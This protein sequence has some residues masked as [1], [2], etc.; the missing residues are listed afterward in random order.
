MITVEN[1]STLTP[2]RRKAI[3]SRSTVDLS[4][5]AEK[6]KVILER[7]RADPQKELFQEYGSYK[8][9]ICL[10]DFKASP[11]EIQSALETLTPELKSALQIA[12]DNIERFHQSQLEKPMYMTEISP[13][14]LT[15]RLTRPLSKVGVYIPGGL[16]S[17]PSS[18]LM[19]IIPAKV[20]GVETIVAATPPGL[21]LKARPEI[22]AACSLAGATEI[23]KLGG[24]WAIG[25]LAYGLAG[26]PKV[27]KIVG[28]GSSWV[29]AAKMAVFG[30]VDVD[31]PAGPSEGFIIADRTAQPLHLAWDFLSQLEHDPQASAVLVTTCQELATTVVSSVNTLS[32]RLERAEIV[33]ESLANAAILY[34]SSLTEAFDFANIYAPEH[35]Q[36]IVEEAISYLGLIKNAGSIFLGPWSPIPAGD[37]ATGPNHVLPTGGSARAFSGLST[38]SFLKKMTFQKLTHAALKEL[39]PTITTLALAEG[40]P[41]HAQT[42]L[43]RS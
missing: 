43:V 13:G 9:N 40:L 37:Y 26:V 22:L 24:A 20:A 33:R 34:C 1:L 15:G 7:L 38:D 18:A 4:K 41:A 27:D 30:E 39:S 17:Y 23:Y 8:N 5:V 12:A 21:D 11:Q 32:H 42:I 10:E 2:E 36:I 29:T 19:N 6:T 16:A 28:P 31:Q 14:L 3:L 35:L 25:S